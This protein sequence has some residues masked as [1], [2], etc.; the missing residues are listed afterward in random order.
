ME[1]D[2]EQ[3]RNIEVPGPRT[4][5]RPTRRKA[6]D[7]G[8]DKGKEARTPEKTARKPAAAAA[9]GQSRAGEDPLQARD[10][11][12]LP[13]ADAEKLNKV[14]LQAVHADQSAEGERFGAEPL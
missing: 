13:S 1:V 11:W 7:R 5:E 9:G 4:P 14:Y 8:K 10:P 3:P 6:A 12:R 2:E